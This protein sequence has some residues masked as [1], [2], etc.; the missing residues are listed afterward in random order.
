MTEETNYGR[1]YLTN[2]H[3]QRRKLVVFIQFLQLLAKNK[4]IPLLIW[5]TEIRKLL[6]FLCVKVSVVQK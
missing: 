3:L 6:S 1:Y 5:K 2:L 4:I